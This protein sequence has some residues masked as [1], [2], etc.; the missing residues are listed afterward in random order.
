MARRLEMWRGLMSRMAGGLRREG[1]GLPH[2]AKSLAW[3][4]VRT[5][6]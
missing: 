4:A 6:P 3:P 5:G 2:Y 1:R